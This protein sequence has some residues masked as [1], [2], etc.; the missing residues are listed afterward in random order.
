M[1][2]K[3]IALIAK[4]P[5]TIHQGFGVGTGAPAGIMYCS[6]RIWEKSGLPSPRSGA[7]T[8]MHP[9]TSSGKSHATT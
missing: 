6:P 4:P 9:T 1:G 7:R 8:T 2:I 3:M 5:I